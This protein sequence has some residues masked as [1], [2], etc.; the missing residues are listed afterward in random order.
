MRSWAS[1]SITATEVGPSTSR[2]S[3]FASSSCRA[4]ADEN[5]E[6][7]WDMRNRLFCAVMVALF[8]VSG[9][10]CAHRAASGYVGRST[11]LAHH[12]EPEH[13]DDHAPEGPITPALQAA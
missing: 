10:G 1:S 6:G 4:R 13:D 11:M 7:S 5:E 2:A 12:A 3:R 9:A 8:T